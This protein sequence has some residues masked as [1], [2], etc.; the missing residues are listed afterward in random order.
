MSEQARYTL[1]PAG[2]EDEA[3][4]VALY[5]T[6]RADA[7]HIDAWPED[8]RD[9][10]Y[11]SQFDLQRRHYETYFPSSEHDIIVVAGEPVGRLW[12]DWRDDEAHMLD[13]GLMPAAR[14][15]GLGATI[16]D[17]LKQRATERSLAMTL[18]VEHNNPDALRFYERH[19]FR[20]LKDIGTHWFM[21]WTPPGVAPGTA[22]S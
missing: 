9:A 13:V 19:G 15:Q 5:A 22:S 16:L 3:F 20:R 10:F 18:N 12:M 6:V 8:Q 17:D 4:L 11:R 21:E 1:R 7:V 14:G 2:P